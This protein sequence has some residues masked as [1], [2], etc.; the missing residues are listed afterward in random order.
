MLGDVS[1]KPTRCPVPRRCSVNTGRTKTKKK[2]KKKSI[3][4][5]RIH[6]RACGLYLDSRP[7]FNPFAL[8]VRLGSRAQRACA[9]PPG[10]RARVVVPEQRQHSFSRRGARGGLHSGEAGSS[11]AGSFVG[12]GSL[13]VRAGRLLRVQLLHVCLAARPGSRS[14]H[15]LPPPARSPACSRSS[16][17][18]RPSPP[19]PCPRSHG[20]GGRRSWSAR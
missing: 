3:V 18:P 7:W 6:E 14:R 19:Q 17:Q 4:N 15:L 12:R 1:A 9:A 5:E 13:G 10:G 11:K 8:Q 16:A 2:R 20:P